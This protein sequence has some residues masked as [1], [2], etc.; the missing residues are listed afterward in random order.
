MN[1]LSHIRE[2][3]RK[4]KFIFSI[5]RYLHIILVFC[6]SFPRKFINML[7]ERS[8][9]QNFQPNKQVNWFINVPSHSNLGDQAMSL[10]IRRWLREYYPN[11]IIY[12]ISRPVLT[13]NFLWFIGHWRRLIQKDDIIFVQSGY[14]SSDK[15]PNEKVHRKVAQIFSENRIVFFPQT[16]N[17]SSIQELEKTAKIYNSHRRIL[18]L[19][20]DSISYDHVAPFFTKIK[21]LLYP[22]IVTT[23]IGK[24][25]LP[26]CK[27]DGIL[28]C[29]RK[30]SEKKYLQAQIK[31]LEEK[32]SRKYR[33]EK[34][35]LIIK[36]KHYNA[37]DYAKI[38]NDVLKYFANINVIVTDRFHGV[39]FALV[40][41]TKVVALDSIDYKVR[42]G[43]KM[44]KKYFYNSVFYAESL[45]ELH[46]TVDTALQKPEDNLD[47]RINVK[48]Y[49]K[50]KN[51]IEQL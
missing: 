13:W 51:E 15:T 23:L 46:K 8:K 47:D 32:L 49:Q 20:R 24:Y 9:L 44:M 21:L 28:F 11:R 45:K 29:I 10:C 12:E 38:I 4:Y 40:A 18:F 50:L 2:K 7:N 3:T 42:E 22:D 36:D 6:L 37:K 1:L 27:K 41:G 26:E 33:V 17:Y 19:A 34:Q 5:L 35:D 25:D 16:A 14:T 43:A 48:F 39:I 30:D 31:Q